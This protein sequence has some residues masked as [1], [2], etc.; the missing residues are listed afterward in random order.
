MSRSTRHEPNAAARH[1]SGVPRSLVAWTGLAAVTL[2][3]G[4]ALDGL[5]LP[6][7]YL[8]AALLAGLA[9]ALGRPGLFTMPDG[10]FRVGQAVAGVAIG[11]YLQSSTITALGARLA[12]GRA[13]VGRDARGSHSAP[14]CCSSASRPVDR[15]TASLG[16]VAG[17]ASGIVAMARELGADDRLVAFMQYLRVLIVVLG[18]PILVALVFPRP[19]RRHHPEHGRDVSAPGRA[20][21]SRSWPR[22][23]APGWRTRSACR[24]G[25]SSGRCCS[26]GA[27]TVSGLAG[28]HE[29]PP[30]LREGAFALIGLQIGL[31]F[32]RETVQAIRALL[33]PVLLSILALLLACFGL[34]WVLT[35]T[36][37]VSLLNAYLAT[38][39]GGLYAVLPIAFGSGGD[40]TFVLAVQ[41]L[42]VFVMVL[43]AP[44]AVRVIVRRGRV[45]Q[46]SAARP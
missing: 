16:M 4:L 25:R 7:G 23:S 22:R 20:G 30:L 3:G 44:A 37:N 36:A 38:T 31:R 21:C 29:V 41:A 1:P 45:P 33:V 26:P 43:A 10:A 5:G 40:P 6:S 32:E 8:F 2:A 39:P 12:A 27:I 28:G 9:L 46:A 42:R 34:A 19:R 17:G 18:T 15:A 11:T 14:A 35:L 24:P 13:R